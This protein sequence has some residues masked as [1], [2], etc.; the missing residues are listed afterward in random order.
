MPGIKNNFNKNKEEKIIDK[1]YNQLQEKF[2][3]KKKQLPDNFNINN[4]FKNSIKYKSY[5]DL[6]HSEYCYNEQKRIIF[7]ESNIP[8]ENIRIY[9]VETLKNNPQERND[10]FESTYKKYIKEIFKDYKTNYLKQLDIMLNC[11]LCFE[12]PN[13]NIINNY[14]ISNYECKKIS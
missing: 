9:Y 8:I 2:F 3:P 14:K 5:Y 13:Y 4:N 11:E 10:F 12:N 1:F 6:N 7:H